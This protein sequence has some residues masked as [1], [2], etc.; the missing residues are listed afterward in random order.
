[1]MALLKIWSLI[2]LASHIQP[3][4]FGVQGEDIFPSIFPDPSEGP[5]ETPRPE[6]PVTRDPFVHVPITEEVHVPIVDTSNYAILNRMYSAKQTDYLYTIDRYEEKLIA[7]GCHGYK[8]DQT[9]GRIMQLPEDDPDCRAA[10]PIYKLTHVVHSTHALVVGLNTVRM[11]QG[12]TWTLEGII[13]YGVLQ[14]GQCGATVP[15]RSLLMPHDDY[16]QGKHLQTTNQT[17]LS[18]PGTVEGSAPT[19]Y[20]WKAEVDRF[21][22]GK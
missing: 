7:G 18:L 21:W 19:F 1:M 12:W 17:E 11:Y 10:V 8:T 3:N 9:M 2:L 14:Y 4:L 5:D 13:G 16:S 22:S 20:I 15:V 6:E